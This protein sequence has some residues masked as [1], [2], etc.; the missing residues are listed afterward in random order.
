MQDYFKELQRRQRILVDG[1]NSLGLWTEPSTSTPYL[2]V[3]V[4][5]PYADEDFVV[6]MINK[7][8]VA[9]T[10]GSY[11]GSNGRGYLRAT[12]FMTKDKIDEALDRISKIKM[13]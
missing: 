7:A 5:E 6:D 1:L 9:F 8:H 12:L 13:W 3:A 10:P 4:P 11:F 2:W